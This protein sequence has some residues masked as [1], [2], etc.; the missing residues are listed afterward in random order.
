M[1]C[2]LSSN[3][4]PSSLYL[5]HNEI[6]VLNV[7]GREEVFIVLLANVGDQGVVG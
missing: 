7:R 3:S 2:L 5:P 6:E 4:P 1:L